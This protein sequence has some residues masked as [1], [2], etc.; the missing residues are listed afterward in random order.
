M[1]QKN[2]EKSYPRVRW[3]CVAFLLSK[4]AEGKSSEE[5][6]NI[7]WQKAMHFQRPY[8][9]DTRHGCCN[10][11]FIFTQKGYMCGCT[12][13]PCASWRMRTWMKAPRECR[14][15]QEPKWERRP[16]KG[17]NNLKLRAMEEDEKWEKEKEKE[18]DS[19]REREREGKKG[20]N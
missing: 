6:W 14:Q 9:Y 19:E 17:G 20:M 2:Q 15:I 12:Y 4:D 18:R 7:R 16:D 5:I 1:N 13:E 11:G 10:R 8:K 3:H